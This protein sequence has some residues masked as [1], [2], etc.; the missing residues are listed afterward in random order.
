MNSVEKEMNEL[1]LP[2]VLQQV[3]KHMATYHSGLLKDNSSITVNQLEAN[4]KKYLDKKQ[5]VASG[6]TLD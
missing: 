3:Q 2:V 6:Y 5:I 1:E 4:T